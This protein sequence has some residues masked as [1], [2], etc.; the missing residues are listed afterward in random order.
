MDRLI[1]ERNQYAGVINQCC[2]IANG[3]TL[4]RSG[5]EKSYQDAVNGL[6]DVNN[7]IAQYQSQQQAQQMQQQPFQQL[8]QPIQ[9]VGPQNTGTSYNSRMASS[10]AQ[11]QGNYGF[12]PSGQKPI[13]QKQFPKVEQ[14]KEKVFVNGALPYLDYIV[15]R[16]HVSNVV[17]VADRENTFSYE[18]KLKSK[19]VLEWMDE[20]S[21]A[22]VDEVDVTNVDN[23][24]P[25]KIIT[26]GFLLYGNIGR[27]VVDNIYNKLFFN[28][29]GSMYSTGRKVTP[30]MA[31]NVVTT[32]L[33]SPRRGKFGVASYKEDGKF[34]GLPMIIVEDLNG[35]NDTFYRISRDSHNNLYTKLMMLDAEY[36]V[37]LL[38]QYDPQYGNFI[39]FMSMRVDEEI[40]CVNL[41]ATKSNGFVNWLF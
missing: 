25:G 5:Y 7:R 23:Y 14:P 35:L 21:I 19:E 13:Q 17:S 10:M 33:K 37:V 1:A 15:D 9:N 30:E 6:N 12:V 29:F 11:N 27:N 31:T 39:K 40:G 3:Q 2:Y 24:Q 26:N 41:R 22:L 32:K 20:D 8:P 4:V 18:I 34:F 16:N 36:P 28:L 38:G